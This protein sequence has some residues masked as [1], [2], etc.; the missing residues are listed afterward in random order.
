MP[1]K[2]YR[3]ETFRTAFSFVP[4]LFYKISAV[5][6]DDRSAQIVA[7]V[8]CEE[9]AGTLHVIASTPTICRAIALTLT[10]LAIQSL[11]SSLVSCVTPPF[12][13]V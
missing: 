4:M 6:R 8:G 13:A 2:K 10:P 12:A 5:Y 1:A 9:D 7:G 11:L 3:P